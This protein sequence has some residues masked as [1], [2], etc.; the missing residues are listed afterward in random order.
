MIPVEVRECNDN[1]FLPKNLVLHDLL[2]EAPYS[3]A[4]ID[5][6]DIY[7]VVRSDEDAA[8]AP[9]EFVEVTSVD[10]N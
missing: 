4:G 8:G 1:G 10:R 9:A 7:R 2:T 3:C 6:A 5:N